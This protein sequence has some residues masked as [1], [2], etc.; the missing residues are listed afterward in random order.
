MDILPLKLGRK[1]TVPEVK[2]MR[3]T[4]GMTQ[5]GSLI[6]FVFSTKSCT[7]HNNISEQK[8]SNSIVHARH[9]F[10]RSHGLFRDYRTLAFQHESGMFSIQMNGVSYFLIIL[11]ALNNWQVYP[12]GMY[13]WLRFSEQFFVLIAEIR[14]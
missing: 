6:T 5:L 1:W 12:Q 10:L 2:V 8:P 11:S 4:P 9:F 13:F 14:H 7:C 3:L